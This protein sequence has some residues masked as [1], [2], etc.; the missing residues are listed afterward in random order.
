MQT[1]YHVFP[2][3]GEGYTVPVKIVEYKHVGN[4]WETR[5]W[6]QLPAG[7]CGWS[8]AEHY[9]D[10]TFGEGYMLLIDMKNKLKIELYETW[11]SAYKAF[12]RK[13]ERIE[14]IWAEQDKRARRRVQQDMGIY[15]F[16]NYGS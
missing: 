15:V 6:N 4:G 7:Q 3:T 16:E 11:N 9:S 1:F 2:L 10:K 8:K 13:S 12:R 5:T 14:K